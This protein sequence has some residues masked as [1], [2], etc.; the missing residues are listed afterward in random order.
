[1]NESTWNGWSAAAGIGLL[2]WVVCVI[3]VSKVAADGHCQDLEYAGPCGEVVEI[4]DQ[5]CY[6]GDG[7]FCYWIPFGIIQPAPIYRCTN[8]ATGSNDCTSTGEAQPQIQYY[9]CPQ[10]CLEDG[11]LGMCHIMPLGEPEP[12]GLPCRSAEL[13]GGQCY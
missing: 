5:P 11:C 12:W 3:N 1:M 13:S 7:N 4:G 8:A 9:T 6:D 2:V 10:E